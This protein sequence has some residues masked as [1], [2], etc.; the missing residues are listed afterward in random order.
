MGVSQYEI[1]GDRYNF[2]YLS[3]VSIEANNLNT[4]IIGSHLASFDQSL[5]LNLGALS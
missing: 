2:V 5:Q 4:H 1:D 3:T